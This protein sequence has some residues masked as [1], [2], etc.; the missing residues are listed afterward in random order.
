MGD[1]TLIIIAAIGGIVAVASV[2]LAL[3]LPTH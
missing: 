3:A 1:R 2:L